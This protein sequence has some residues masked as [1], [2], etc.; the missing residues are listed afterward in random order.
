MTMN[1]T[2]SDPTMVGLGLFLWAAEVAAVYVLFD[3]RA[4]WLTAAK[5]LFLVGCPCIAIGLLPS[6]CESKVAWFTSSALAL[7][8]Y[9][10]FYY[11]AGEAFHRSPVYGKMV[12]AFAYLLDTRCGQWVERKGWAFIDW[13]RANRVV[14]KGDFECSICCT[15]EIRLHVLNPC[16]HAYCSQCAARMKKCA[17]CRQQVVSLIRFHYT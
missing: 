16:G 4:R 17:H 10:L 14:E 12:G 8:L 2:E 6:M 15:K 5:W 3:F 7:A 1:C 11:Q 13:V 9:I